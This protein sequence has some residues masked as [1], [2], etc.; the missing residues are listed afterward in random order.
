MLK[1]LTKW[2][3]TLK[4]QSDNSKVSEVI[5]RFTR[6]Q[7]DTNSLEMKS[8]NGIKSSKECGN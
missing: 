1:G 4:P 6:V 7:M 5:K 2:L 3:D 8:E